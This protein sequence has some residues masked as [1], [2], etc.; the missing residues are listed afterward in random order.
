MN[1]HL[2]SYP[3]ALTCR[4]LNV[5]TSG[6]YA[7]L[8]RKPKSSALIDNVKALYWRHKARLG[9]PSLVHDVRDEGYNVPERTVSRALKGLGLRSKAVRKFKYRAD[10][11]RCHDMTPN[12]LNRQFNPDK[13][14]TV[15]VTDITYIK[16]GEGWLY[17][18]VIIDLFGRKV[19]GWQT[20][21]RIDR[22]LVCNTLKMPY[23]DVSFQ[24]TFYST[25]TEEVN[26]AVRILN[27]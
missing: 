18:C 10:S 16:T 25:V 24:K 7:W 13:P 6:Y 9:A 14:N 27:D 23:F 5:S 20:S 26:I 11:S 1:R 19:I 12:T 2:L 15:W 8:K 4:R 3:A 22:H 21:Q 17:L